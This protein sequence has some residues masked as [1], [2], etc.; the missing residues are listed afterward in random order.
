MHNASQTA[1]IRMQSLIA[2]G[3]GAA[4]NSVRSFGTVRTECKQPKDAAQTLTDFLHSL[5]GIHSR[6]S[7][8]AV[9]L[10]LLLLGHLHRLFCLGGEIVGCCFQ[11]GRAVAGVAVTSRGRDGRRG[12][13]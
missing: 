1:A 3:L 8:R 4:F 2:G 5:R 7:I 12:V 11:R 13:C 9:V 10:L 6:S